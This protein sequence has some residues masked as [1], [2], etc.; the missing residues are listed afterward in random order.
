M[1]LAENTGTLGIICCIPGEQVIPDLESS[2]SSGT[3][4]KEK[5]KTW[6]WWF[7]GKHRTWN[8]YRVRNRTPIHTCRSWQG[9]GWCFSLVGRQRNELD[10][11]WHESSGGAKPS[12]SGCFFYLPRCIS[13]KNLVPRSIWKTSEQGFTQSEYHASWRLRKIK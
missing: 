13:R 8:P 10:R 7:Q 5:Q 1:R 2:T 9:Q 4:K 3:W 6:S 11:G 12:L